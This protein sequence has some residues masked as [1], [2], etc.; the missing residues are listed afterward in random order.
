MPVDIRIVNGQLTALFGSQ[1]PAALA[2]FGDHQ[3]MVE[4]DEQ[5]QL[6]FTTDAA[7]AVVGFVL[8]Q[9]ARYEARRVAR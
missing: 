1:A 6:E 5:I 4:D 2:P 9:G 8:S 7:G 3:F